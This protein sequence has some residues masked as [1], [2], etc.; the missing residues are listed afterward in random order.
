MASKMKLENL[1][2]TFKSA[3]IELTKKVD[4]AS[5]TTVNNMVTEL[6]NATPVDTGNAKESW[7][8]NANPLSVENTADYIEHLNSG[9]SKQAPSH[10]IE[11]V[12]LKYGTPIGVI[13]E[14]KQGH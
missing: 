14:T 13:V 4:K 8:I 1:D 7:G 11:T 6:K 9:S 2:A 12:A 3:L 10:F 5:L